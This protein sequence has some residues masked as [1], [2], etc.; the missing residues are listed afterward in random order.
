MYFGLYNLSHSI[1][2][3]QKAQGSNSKALGNCTYSTD[4]R[5][6]NTSQPETHHVAQLT[7]AEVTEEAAGC[8]PPA[9]PRELCRGHMVSQMQ[10]TWC[11]SFC[12]QHVQRCGPSL[13]VPV[14]YTDDTEVS[15][16]KF[17]TELIHTKH[18][19][20][21]EVKA[22]KCDNKTCNSQEYNILH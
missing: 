9:I 22:I 5:C 16:K 13:H 12:L 6:P 17:W 2:L 11:T 14:L 8:M 19:V 4:Y 15:S 3:A 10:P 18:Q 1:N 20:C 21:L 7:Q